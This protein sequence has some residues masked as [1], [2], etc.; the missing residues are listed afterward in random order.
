MRINVTVIPRSSRFKIESKNGSIKIHLK[1]APESNKANIELIKELRRLLDA[2]VRIVSGLS[3]R[4][5]ILEIDK[6]AEDLKRL[7]QI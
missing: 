2:E 7:L 3:S 1:S 6:S 5:K 4:K